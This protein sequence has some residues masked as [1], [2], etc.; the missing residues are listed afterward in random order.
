MNEIILSKVSYAQSTEFICYDIGNMTVLRN[1]VN[2]GLAMKSRMLSTSTIEQELRHLVE[3]ENYLR[4][5][6]LED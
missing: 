1:I 2:Y 6:K 3:L 4:A 5:R